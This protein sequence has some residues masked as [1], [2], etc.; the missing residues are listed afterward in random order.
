MNDMCSSYAWL[1]LLRMKNNLAGILVVMCS[2]VNQISTA[3]QS[4]FDDFHTQR[5]PMW[6]SFDDFP[7]Q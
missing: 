4:I 3:A 1:I 6:F 7:P 2:F 5:N